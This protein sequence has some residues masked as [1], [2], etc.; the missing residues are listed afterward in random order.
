MFLFRSGEYEDVVQKDQDERIQV[1]RKDI[2]HQT[3]EL[4]WGISNP[5][6]NHEEFVVP[7]AR[8]ER[9]LWDVFLAHWHLPISRSQVDDAEHLGTPQTIER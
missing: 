6:G 8:A 1:I 3:H 5:K 9:S 4:C 7:P 2:V